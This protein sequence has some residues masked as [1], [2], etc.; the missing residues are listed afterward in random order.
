MLPVVSELANLRAWSWNGSH[1]EPANT[2]PITDRG[3][4][5]GMSVFESLRINKGTPLFLNDHLRLLRLSCSAVGFAAPENALADCADLLRQAGDGFARIY[6][7]A[8]DGPVTAPAD[9]CR[10][11]V[12]VES[13]EPIHRRVY[14][15]G[16]DVQVHPGAF[17][18]EF[19]GLKTGNY[20]A[21]LR[22]LNAGVA[23][24][25]N[26]TLLVSPEGLLISAAMAN[27]FLVT[28]GKIIT[29]IANFEAPD[30]SSV[31][32]PGVVRE[33]VMRTFR[34]TSAGFIRRAELQSATE[35]FLTSSWLGIMPVARID[36][37]P[38]LRSVTKTVFDAYR[39]EFQLP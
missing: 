37:R 36:G 10:V 26:E 25:C 29:P 2:V 23:K 38:L 13:R 4:R 31:C 30:C 7:T 17:A 8:G 14:H 33:W 1:F 27:V 22:A 15:R 35:I 6:V 34:I 3:F 39:A 32:R 12:F 19:P 21:H 16:Y 24:Q 11:L 28:G 18:E 5:Y 9:A 20:W